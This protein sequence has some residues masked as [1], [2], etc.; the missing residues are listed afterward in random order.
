MKNTALLIA[1]TLIFGFGYTQRLVNTS[2]KNKDL[3]SSSISNDKLNSTVF[4]DSIFTVTIPQEGFAKSKV[5]YGLKNK[6]GSIVVEAKYEDIV[7]LHPEYD[8]YIITQ[9][10]GK[11]LVT[12]EGKVILEPIYH[13]INLINSKDSL[14]SVYHSK[15]QIQLANLQGEMLSDKYEAI[16]PFSN[17]YLI[18]LQGKWG[19][20]NPNLFV[21]IKP[22]YKSIEI[23]N[24]NLLVTKDQFNLFG[25]HDIDGM[26]LKKLKYDKIIPLKSM[27]NLQGFIV[28]RF[29]NSG[30]LDSSLN[31]II[32][33]QADFLDFFNTK[34]ELLIT[35]T[36]HKKMVQSLLDMEG[37]QISKIEFSDI[38]QSTLNQDYFIVSNF[39]K[40][41]TRDTPHSKSTRK[42][43]VL[44]GI[45]NANGE[46]ILKMDYDKLL[47]THKENIVWIRR[48]NKWCLF[49]TKTK[50]LNETQYSDVNRT[51]NDQY[52]VQKGGF[53]ENGFFINGVFGL[54]DSNFSVVIPINYE[55]IEELN[56]LD[57]V[58]MVKKNG[59]RGL[60]DCFG[61]EILPVQYDQ[62]T[63]NSNGVF[64][65]V[66]KNENYIT[67]DYD[68]IS[69]E[70]SKQLHHVIFKSLSFCVPDSLIK[71]STNG[72]T[73]GIMTDKGRVLIE[74]KFPN[75]QPIM[76]EDSVF[77]KISAQVSNNQF[78]DDIV[79]ISGPSG[80]ISSN[81]DT[82]IP[83]EF[84][85][86]TSSENS[87]IIAS[88][89]SGEKILY[90][91]KN[92][93]SKEIKSYKF[94][95][96]IKIGS[97]M[98][99][100]VA[101]ELITSNQNPI[102]HGKFGLIDT[103]NRIL[104]EPNYRYLYQHGKFIIGFTMETKFYTLF[105]LSG[106]VILDNLESILP[107]SDSI[108]IF[109]KE[110]IVKVFNAAS[111][112]YVYEENYIDYMFPE[113]VFRNSK[114]S[115]TEIKFTNNNFTSFATSNENKI[116]ITNQNRYEFF[117]IKNKR[118]KWGIINNMG[119]IVMKPKYDEIKMGEHDLVIVGK[120]EE[121][122]NDILYG[123]VELNND[124]VI[125]LNYS[126]IVYDDSDRLT[127]HCF[128]DL[129]YKNKRI[130]KVKF[131]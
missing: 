127:F 59:D 10:G 17:G 111:G 84:S 130:S 112:F 98:L 74:P 13:A 5:C 1:I 81:G 58:F 116:N 105:D 65:G 103:N 86:L 68:L 121:E 21:N 19:T 76:V 25:F 45:L 52:I 131:Y 30:L 113:P 67:D 93:G 122:T 24:K 92:P 71:Y 33:L 48:N 69:L 15:N 39:K 14:I 40:L 85:K 104:I 32:P 120:K 31:T 46:F 75:I 34:N 44:Y 49:D 3:S 37:N 88:T 7:Q 6:S 97:S 99:F 126:N 36:N 114:N 54:L 28:E 125:P 61:K 80:I 83:C 115:L 56:N 79:E 22:N 20:L 12:R 51:V 100:I 110:E 96:P 4:K 43:E 124:V 16:S 102:T 50:K 23:V 129:K 26:L 108:F 9:K 106:K 78:I 89:F 119:E 101:T 53:H 70:K 90:N 64:I 123:V 11:G 118:G 27:G 35:K 77:Y 94:I 72:T 73:F 29:E 55:K 107:I 63:F 8:Y 62:L 95:D 87:W 2:L 42:M 18:K 91:L 41:N 57:S 66:K 60:I 128:N 38:R 47:E 109:R 82:I 117:G